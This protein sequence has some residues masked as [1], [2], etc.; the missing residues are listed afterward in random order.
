MSNN[1]LYKINISRFG[2]IIIAFVLIT[3]SVINA[4]FLIDNIQLSKII[5]EKIVSEANP[6]LDRQLMI[7]ATTMLD[8]FSSIELTSNFTSDTLDSE[9]T[10]P[11]NIAEVSVEIQ[12]ASGVT[13]AA[14]NLSIKLADQG[15]KISAISTAPTK[16]NKTTI[17]YK[18]GKAAVAQSLSD[19]LLIEEW[20]AELIETIE[21]QPDIIIV[22]GK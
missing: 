11:A 5:D 6:R 15:Y 22:L 13:G 16:Q 14:S 3:I 8:S 18:K 9:V 2:R 20:S 17:F 21:Q 19:L 4:R 12:N 7:K 10:I 1:H